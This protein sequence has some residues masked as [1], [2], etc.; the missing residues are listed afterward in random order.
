ML[1]T[2]RHRL[3]LQNARRLEL[4]KLSEAAGLELLAAELALVAGTDTRV[5]SQPADA[6]AIARLCDGLPLALQIIAALLAAHPSRP[7]SSMAADLQDA[8]TRLDEMRYRE[9]GGAEL[10]VGQ[11]S[12]CLT[13]SWTPSRPGSSGC[14]RST[15]ARKSLL[16]P[17]LR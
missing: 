15:W 2:S 1:V 7:L 3:P 6:A 4:D 10:A 13:T 16:R 17:W 8:R 14:C 11:R 9:P 5:A 12:T